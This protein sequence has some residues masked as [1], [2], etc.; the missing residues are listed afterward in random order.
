MRHWLNISALIVAVAALALIVATNMPRED[1]DSLI[2]VSYDPTRELYQQLN[3]A[4]AADYARRTGRHLRIVQ[5]HGGSARQSRAVIAGQPADVVTLG[6][7]SDVDALRKR[8]LIA[9]GWADRLP[10]HSQPYTSTIV[11]VVR[12]RNPKAISDW[13]DLIHPGV[14]IITP[15]PKTS[16]NG[17]LSALAAWGAIVTRG[18]TAD[19]ARR[20]LVKFYQ[21]VRVL[22]AGARGSAATFALAEIGDVHLTWENEAIRE[23]AESKGI[24]EIVY[25]PVSILAEPYV[26]W[27]D[28]NVQRHGS[29]ADARNYLEFLFSDAAQEI[30]ANMGYR[31]YQQPAHNAGPRPPPIV[32][33]P[34]S[35]IARDWDDAQ[36]K[37]FAENGVIESALKESRP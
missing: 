27:V 31:P 11:F 35:A 9:D 7:F 25:P 8:G 23:A 29:L 21:H 14:E 28:V 10:N 12:Q 36:E 22:D 34:I 1:R 26:A 30:I 20:Y 3:A 33:F 6:L 32:L 18:G 2:N 15:D 13:P 19:E 17:K 37:F 5:S 24:L 16:G 4:F